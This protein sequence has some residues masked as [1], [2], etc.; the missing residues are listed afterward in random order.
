L[1]AAPPAQEEADQADVFAV[2]PAPTAFDELLVSELPEGDWDGAGD[3]AYLALKA[4][5]AWPAQFARL[6]WKKVSLARKR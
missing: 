4:Y 5:I 6:R 3:G 1:R 2:A